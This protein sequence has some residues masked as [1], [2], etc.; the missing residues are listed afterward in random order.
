[1]LEIIGLSKRYTVN[2]DTLVVLDKIDCTI[3]EGD[4]V[5]IMGESGSGKSTFLSCISTLDTPTN[6]KIMFHDM[7]IAKATTSQKQKLRLSSFGYIFQENHMIDSLTIIEN[8]MI[9]NIQVNRHSKQ[10]AYILFDQLGI[11]SIANK[12]PHQISGG[13]RQRAAI[14]RALINKPA[15]LFAD[16]PTASLNPMF[17]K[18]IMTILKDLNEQGQTI[19]MVTHSV[20]MASYG[21][22]LLLLANGNFSVDENISML[23]E[24]QKQDRIV[25]LALDIL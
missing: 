5:M 21:K 9:A 10:D 19:I 17:A 20:K 24:S 11:R 16:E 15:I 14:A 6:G 7:N 2:K 13:E 1:M 18:E 25:S 23:E 3:F 8:V 12:Y 22:R 4:F